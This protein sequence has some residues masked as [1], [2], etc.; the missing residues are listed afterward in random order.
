[1]SRTSDPI[2]A[3]GAIVREA[4]FTPTQRLPRTNSKVQYGN[5]LEGH[6]DLI[7]NP[8]YGLSGNGATE[9]VTTG[10]V[11]I[12]LTVKLSDVLAAL[13]AEEAHGLAQGA[14]TKI[15]FA[16][17]FTDD[18]GALMNFTGHAD[19]R[20]A[21]SLTRSGPK[22]AAMQYIQRELR[23]REGLEVVND[24]VWTKPPLNP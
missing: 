21:E 6:E 10:I 1:M 16:A 17:G 15:H 22:L 18:A 9:V 24:N 23:R 20:E 4:L 3:T 13:S 12:Q 14:I 5:S 19:Y 2:D 8:A 7:G 11:E